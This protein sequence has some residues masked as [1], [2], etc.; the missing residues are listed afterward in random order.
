MSSFCASKADETKLF[1]KNTQYLH[2][3]IRCN[4]MNTCSWPHNFYRADSIHIAQEAWGKML[5]HCCTTCMHE[6][7]GVVVI[8]AAP[9]LLQPSSCA[10][11]T[12]WH[13]A[14]ECGQWTGKRTE[15]LIWPQQSLLTLML[16]MYLGH[17]VPVYS[18]VQD[19][20]ASG[21]GGWRV[22]VWLEG[23]CG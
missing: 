22:C 16:F 8:R 19:G 4:F 17:L 6:I 23:M 10:A 9:S 14:Q 3:A 13:P 20:L 18:F 15:H 11:S 12:Y 21:V 1:K 5:R 7:W 2:N